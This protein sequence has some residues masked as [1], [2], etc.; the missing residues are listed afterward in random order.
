M[1]SVLRE[2]IHKSNLF[3]STTKLRPS[4]VAQVKNLPA[5]QESRFH[6]WVGK[7]PW[8]REWQPTLVFL[9][10]ESH[11]QRN[12]EGYSPQGH[13]ESDTMEGI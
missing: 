2:L 6:P 3:V 13:R 11:G 5:M 9:P 7:T 8:R 10:G 12:L 1:S 4:L